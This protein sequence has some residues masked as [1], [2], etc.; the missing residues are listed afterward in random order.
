MHKD[1]DPTPTMMA[2]YID[3]LGPAE[4]IRVKPLPVPVAGPTDVLVAVTA[5]VVNPVDTFI[6]S[7]R[8]RTAMPFPFIIG[9]DLVGTVVDAPIGTGF[10]A[11]EQVWCNSL[12]HDGRQGSFAQF[13]VVPAARLYR[14]PPGVDPIVA[15]AVAHPAATAYLGWFVHGGLRAGDTVYIG[16][17]AGNVGRAAITM[18]AEA[19]ARVIA[20]ARPADEA[21]CRAAGAEVVIDYSDPEL[22]TRLR[23]VAPGGVDLYWDTSGRGNFAHAMQA[24]RPRGRILLSAGQVEPLPVSS[25]QLYTNDVSLRGFV[26]SRA[27]VTELADAAQLINRLLS[28]GRLTARIA[29]QMPLDRASE[30]H[31]RLEAGEVSGR[32][33]LRPPVEK[34]P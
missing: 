28:D 11:G 30:A 4:S 5:V 29:D 20:G 15:V 2:A 17:G 13:A 10:I 27:A 25:W 3:Q 19:G 32:L 24:V 33:I 12:G 8:Y 9:R 22:A 7:G 21:A 23:D 6:R 31:R 26:I 18:A 16:G 1:A 14:L 34:N